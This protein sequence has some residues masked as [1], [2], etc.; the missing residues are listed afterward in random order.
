MITLSAHAKVNL[1]L[2][3]IAKRDDGY[4][5]IASVLQTIS[6]ADELSFELASKVEC[7]CHDAQ[8]DGIELL[9]DSVLKTASLLRQETGCREGGIIML[10]NLAVPRAAGLGSSASVPAAVL[11]GLNELWSLNLPLGKLARLA[12]RIGSDTPFFIY[13]GTA[14]VKGRGEQVTPLPSPSPTLLVLLK[15]AMDPVPGKTTRMYGMLN[16]SHF[17]HGGLTDSLVRELQQGTALHFN[18]LCNTFESVAFDFFPQLGEYRKKFLDAGAKRVHLAG[19]GPTLFTL[20]PDRASGEA[21]VSRLKN[22]GLEAY[23]VHTV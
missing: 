19:A 4:H 6:L 18:M 16:E 1:T 20:V 5:E 12:S 8:I 10:D 2:E 21:L 23:L 9:R 3:V 11:R 17:R 22:E 14:L 13:G 7:V 15:P